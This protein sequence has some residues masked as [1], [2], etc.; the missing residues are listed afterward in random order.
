MK[1]TKGLE[2]YKYDKQMSSKRE[3]ENVQLWKKQGHLSEKSEMYK[4][5]IE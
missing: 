3:Y 5:A 1:K 2:I 4:Y